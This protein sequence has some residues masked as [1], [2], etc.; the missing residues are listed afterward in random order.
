MDKETKTIDV[1]LP[2]RWEDLYNLLSLGKTKTRLSFCSR[3]LAN[4]TKKQ[5]HLG[6]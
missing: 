5:S 4:L 2:T 6:W 3:L 1:K